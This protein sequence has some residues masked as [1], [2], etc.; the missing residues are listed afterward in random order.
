MTTSDIIATIGVTTLLIAFFLQTINKLKATDATYII[1]NFIGA[2]LTGYS[3]WIINF[4]PLVV[5]E[6]VWAAVSLF[7]LIKLLKK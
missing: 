6:A 2:A 3:S 7:G 4:I 1:L 5:L